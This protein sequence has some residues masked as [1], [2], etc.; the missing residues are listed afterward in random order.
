M[1]RGRAEHR[2]GKGA[3]RGPDETAKIDM[4]LA[5]EGQE[6]RRGADRALQLVRCERGDGRDSGG[7]QRGNGEE[8]AAARHRVDRP[9]E[10]GDADQ[11]GEDFGREFHAGAPRCDRPPWPV[12][13]RDA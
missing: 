1:D 2:A 7:H 6:G 10:E 12:S 5:P 9:G 4:P 8:T 11:E 3:G 13:G